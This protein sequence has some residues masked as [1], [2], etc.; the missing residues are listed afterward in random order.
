MIYRLFISVEGFLKD[1]LT[2]NIF[3]DVVCYA[4]VYEIRI[5]FQKICYGLLKLTY[6]SVISF[7]TV[8]ASY[9]PITPRTVTDSEV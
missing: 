9:N 6:I 7:L 8:I 5:R 3:G 2:R 4:V 1:L